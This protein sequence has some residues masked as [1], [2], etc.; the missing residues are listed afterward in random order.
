M[1]IETTNLMNYSD[2]SV[3]KKTYSMYYL[4]VIDTYYL[5]SGG[6]LNEHR[7]WFAKNYEACAE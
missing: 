4:Y 2:K 1:S 5:L 7:D 6:E 3:D